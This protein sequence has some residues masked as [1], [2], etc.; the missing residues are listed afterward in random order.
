LYPWI[1]EAERLPMKK[2]DRAIASRQSVL[3]FVL[4]FRAFFE[5]E[6]IDVQKEI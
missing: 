6:C 1:K 2:R 4:G 3:A 5:V